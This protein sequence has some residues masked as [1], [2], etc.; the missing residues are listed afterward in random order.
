MTPQEKAQAMMSG[1]GAADTSAAAKF[2]SQYGDYIAIAADSMKKKFEYEWTPNDSVAFGQYAQTWESFRDVFEAD[3]TS[4]NTLGEALKSNLGLVAMAYSSL[5]IQNLASVQ[6]LTD[7][8]GTVYFRH[9]VA[10]QARGD[11]QAGADLIS[12]MGA[13]NKDIGSFTSETQD[14]SV[15]IADPATVTY[16]VQLGAELR[17]GSVRV[18]VA[19]GKIK[20]MDDG[21]GHILGV[22]I[23]A[24]ASTINYKTG[25]AV[26]KFVDLTGKGVVA[27]DVIDVIYSQSVIDS[28]TIPTMKWI[29]KSK[30]VNA[31]YY[32]LQSQ[33]SNLSEVVLRKRFGAE[34]SDQVSAD[35]VSQITSSVMFKAIQKLRSAAIRNEQST[36][37]SITW[38]ITAPT[39]VSDADH[40]KTFDD[41]LIEATGVMYKVAG[42]GDITAMVVGTTGKKILK[43]A[44]MRMIKNAV[45]G[46]HLCGMYDGI[47]VYYAPNTVLGDNEMLVVYRGQNWYEAP[48]V[49]APF[50][51]VTTVSGN[52]IQNVLTNANAAYHSAALEN[53]VDGFVVRINFTN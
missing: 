42:K 40:R 53:V 30:V 41:K 48:L 50:L 27:Q 16:N 52:A 49:Y 35:L 38:S 28:N 45:S 14:V 46:P 11:I 32:V 12:P 13:I 33:Y 5:P 51:P 8:A 18:T 4:R 19:G 20:A 9:G 47:P 21:E 25:A 10:A 36:G 1:A 23:D 34:L 31:D 44:G 29:L 3:L 6:P 39:A 43:T 22:G 17:P 15:S 7:E 2:E 24:E 26:L 37:T